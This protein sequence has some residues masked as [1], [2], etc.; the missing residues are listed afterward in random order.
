VQLHR[1]VEF[2]EADE[3]IARGEFDDEKTSEYME[4]KE[5]V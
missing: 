4:T 2:I 1:P 5:A 3:R